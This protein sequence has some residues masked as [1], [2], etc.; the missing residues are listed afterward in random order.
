MDEDEINP[1]DNCN[2]DCDHWEAMYC[3]ELCR[4]TY[5]D[6]EPPCD[7]CDTYDI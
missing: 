1:C 2:M 4:A 5:G 3:C 6:I 7:M